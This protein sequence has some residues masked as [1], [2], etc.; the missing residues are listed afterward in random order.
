MKTGIA[1]VG[2]GYWGPNLVRN[3]AG[4]ENVD[5]R[6]VCDLDGGL[7]AGLAERFKVERWTTSLADVLAD[8]DVAGVAIAT[9]AGTH[10]VI[11]EA[12]FDAGKDVLVEKPLASNLEEGRSLVRKADDT[13]RVLMIDHTFCYTS[14]VQHLRDVIRSGEI[15]DFQYYDSVRINL[16]LV[17][18]DIDVI[19]DLAPH[20]LSILDFILPDDV[21]P[22]TVTAQGSDPLGVGHACVA[23]VTIEMSNGSLAHLHL[24]W[25]S[26]VKVRTILI[27]GSDKMMVWDDLKPTQRLSIYDAG[28]RLGDLSEPRRRE[29]LVSYRIGDMV[30]PAIPEKEALGRVAAEFVQAI[31]TRQAPAT[32]GRAGL[33]VLELLDAARRSLD[34]SGTPVSV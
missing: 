24:N 4:A 3:F 12:C 34:A 2:A 13:G 26:P 21:V 9:P 14:T 23:Y 18:S 20:D 11:A 8:P 17:Q 5:V 29:A 1:V 25:L 19:W 22:V 10:A 30:A 31:K 32:D 7:A 27:G 33:R 28:A 16:G 15:G 6:W